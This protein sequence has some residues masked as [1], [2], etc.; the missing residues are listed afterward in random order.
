[1]MTH[2]VIAYQNCAVMGLMPISNLRGT[3]E[4]TKEFSIGA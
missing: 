4:G 2:V 1:M 3:K